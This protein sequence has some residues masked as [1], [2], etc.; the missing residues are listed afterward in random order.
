MTAGSTVRPA[1]NRSPA[2]SSAAAPA[3]QPHA[4]SP[5]SATLAAHRARRP[6]RIASAVFPPGSRH[7]EAAS[8]VRNPAG[9]A[10]WRS[11]GQAVASAPSRNSPPAG[12]AGDRLQQLID[13]RQLKPARKRAQQAH[14]VPRQPAGQHPQVPQHRRRDHMLRP[15]ERLPRHLR[16]AVR[17]TRQRPQRAGQRSGGRQPPRRLP[18]KAAPGQC[19]RPDAARHP[20]GAHP[21]RPGSPR[22][23][24]PPAAGPSSPVPRPRTRSAALL[25]S[26]GMR[27][28]A[29]SRDRRASR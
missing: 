24:R 17:R 27:C 29:S 1:A 10:A 13:V 19:P 26:T 16:A 7:G 3:A 25:T 11:C 15:G 21:G 9:F 28:P 8:A 12:Q 6:S 2:S 18:A 4:G 22:G 5:A 14:A 20:S 23:S